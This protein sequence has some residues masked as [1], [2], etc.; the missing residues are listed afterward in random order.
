MKSII[1]LGLSLS[2][3]A[4]GSPA[5]TS[6]SLTEWNQR[7]NT[8]SDWLHRPSTKS[9]WLHR[10]NTTSGWLHPPNTTSGWLHPPMTDDVRG[11][12]TPA[13][14]DPRARH[15]VHLSHEP[16]KVNITKT[17]PPLTEHKMVA[18]VVAAAAVIKTE[19]V[20]A[21]TGTLQGGPPYPKN[22][23]NATLS[24]TTLSSVLR[25]EQRLPSRHPASPYNQ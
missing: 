14:V 5:E 13:A 25:M 10:P 20:A 11:T 6:A 15:P 17:V 12:A 8:T 4:I 23:S 3:L 22:N 24:K 19:I 18:T 1:S 16:F 9:D 7:P 2:I 21:V